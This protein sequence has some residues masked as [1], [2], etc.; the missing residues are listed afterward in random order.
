MKHTI[1]GNTVEL[2]FNKQKQEFRN[3]VPKFDFPTQIF[4]TT[5]WVNDILIWENEESLK[6]IQQMVFSYVITEIKE[7]AK[8]E[9]LD[10][11]QKVTI[12]WNKCWLIDDGSHIC[13]MLPSEY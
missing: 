11:L 13:L 10:Y 12:N 1:L 9:K 5:R 7:R 3:I 6:L 2:F 4:V 8:E